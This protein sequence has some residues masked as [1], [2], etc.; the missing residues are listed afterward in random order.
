M[1]NLLMKLKFFLSIFIFLSFLTNYSF[2]KDI[3]SEIIKKTE[4][5][6]KI[7]ENLLLSIALTE[8]GR[9]VGN[10]FFHGHGQLM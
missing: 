2:A 5:D 8:S 3:C 10:N 1:I 6:L 7:P 9:K 4:I